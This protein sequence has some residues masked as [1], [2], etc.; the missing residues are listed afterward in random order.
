MARSSFFIGTVVPLPGCGRP[1]GMFKRLAVGPIRLD[2]EGFQG[3]QH[4]DLRVHGGPDKAVHLYPVAHYVSL[5]SHFPEAADDLVP[6]SL[7]ENISTVGLDES[8]VCIGDIFKLGEALVQVSQPR[9]PCWKIDDRFGV[10]GVAALIGE[11]GLTGWY[12]RV[13]QPGMVVPEATLDLCDSD[14]RAPTLQA[15]MALCRLHRPDPVELRRLATVA[16][17]SVSWRQK[18]EARAAWLEANNPQPSR[19]PLLHWTPGPL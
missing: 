18:I 16:G 9:N 12:F 11:L 13:I 17:I 3:D 19:P 2:H 10:D 14:R 5:A 8:M 15:A 1:S 6:G 7:G 4:A